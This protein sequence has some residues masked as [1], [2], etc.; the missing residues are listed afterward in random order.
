MHV[1]KR[2]NTPEHNDANCN[3]VSSK[4]EINHDV[5]NGIRRSNVI[6]FSRSTK[7][8]KYTSVRNGNKA[9]FNYPMLECSWP[10]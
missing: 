7:S 9:E 5:I 4:P 1:I 6:L 3:C 10:E 2:P 8:V